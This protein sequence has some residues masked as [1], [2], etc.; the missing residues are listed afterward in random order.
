[1]SGNR[2]KSESTRERI[3]EAARE[4]FAENGYQKT[5]VVEIAQEAGLSEAAMYEYFKGKEDLLLTIP[6]LWVTDLLAEMEDQLFGVEGAFNKLRKYVWWTFR[7]IEQSPMNAKVVYLFLKTNKNFLQTE[8]YQNVRILYAQLVEIF[9]EGRAS[10][11]M[12]PELDP[13]AAQAVVVAMIDHT[14]TRWLLKDMSYPLFKN[15]E[16]TYELLVKAFHREEYVI[17]S[18]R[19]VEEMIKLD[20]KR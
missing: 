1:M 18:G 2:K 10:G 4:L 16:G 5:T 19:S 12:N 6:D 11:E 9:E 7:R 14:V 20:T 17:R 3:I 15:V 13:Y 8:V